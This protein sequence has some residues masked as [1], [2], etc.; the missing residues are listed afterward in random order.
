MIKKKTNFYLQ[1]KHG[2]KKHDKLAI[3]EENIKKQMRKVE[4]F[5]EDVERRIFKHSEL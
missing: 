4:K 2:D 1:N 5:Q 3:L